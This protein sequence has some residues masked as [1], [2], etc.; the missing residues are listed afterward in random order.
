MSPL[1]NVEL[2]RVG[3]RL[4]RP[5]L[6]RFRAERSV[7]PV[8]QP[9]RSTKISKMRGL[10]ISPHYADKPT[11]SSTAKKSRPA[12]TATR[13]NLTCGVFGSAIYSKSYQTYWGSR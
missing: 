6:A 8:T 12:Y 9:S 13:Q 11:T 2:S 5:S 4:C 10:A 1:G 7:P 3:E